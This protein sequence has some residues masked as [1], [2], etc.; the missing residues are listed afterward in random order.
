MD[1][2][3]V[4]IPAELFRTLNNVF[5]DA[6]SNKPEALKKSLILTKIEYNLY[7]KEDSNV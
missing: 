3:P 1:K 7:F 6:Y 4:V 2:K 5:V